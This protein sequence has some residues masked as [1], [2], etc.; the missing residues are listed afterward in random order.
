MFLRLSI[1][2]YLPTYLL[3][4]LYERLFRYIG[5]RYPSKVE[6]SGREEDMMQK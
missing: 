4:A 2:Q 1:N 5:E 3:T 6:G